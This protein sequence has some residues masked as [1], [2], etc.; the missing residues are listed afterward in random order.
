MN[1]VGE[2]TYARGSK[3]NVLE[4]NL[5]GIGNSLYCCD[6]VCKSKGKIKR[7]F[8]SEEQEQTINHIDAFLRDS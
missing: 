3:Q 8:L 2:Q 7:F 4:K 6:L 5:I 1:K